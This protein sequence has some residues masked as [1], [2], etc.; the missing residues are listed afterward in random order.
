MGQPTTNAGGGNPV[1]SDLSGFNTADVNFATPGQDVAAI[2]AGG[3]GGGGGGTPLDL[4]SQDPSQ[5]VGDPLTDPFFGSENLGGGG[6]PFDPLTGSQQAGAAVPP[7][8]GGAQSGDVG[9]QQQQRPSGQTA[10]GGP[11]Q[12]VRQPQS[13]LA[14]IARMI[15]GQQQGP[16]WIQ[17]AQQ[18][19]STLPQS[20]FT[21]QPFT[22]LPPS[23]PASFAERFAGAP[24]EAPASPA[25][26]P[27]PQPSPGPMRFAGAEPPTGVAGA[28]STT[29]QPPVTQGAEA[30]A[31][32][33][34][35]EATAAAAETPATPTEAAP[36]TP[37]TPQT[38]QEQAG[39][40][41][42]QQGGQQQRP[43]N[44]LASLA[45]ALQKLLQGNING[46]IA[47]LSGIGPQGG[48]PTAQAGMAGAPSPPTGETSPGAAPTGPGPAPTRTGRGPVGAEPGAAPGQAVP[49]AAPGTATP[50]TPAAATAGAPP[51]APATSAAPGAAPDQAAA[52][53]AGGAPATQ[54][55]ANQRLLDY[56]AGRGPTTPTVENRAPAQGGAQPSAQDNANYLTQRGGHS[57]RG[58]NL[59]RGPYGGY[60][61]NPQMA[62]RLAAAGRE[63]ERTHP[64]QRAQFGEG[65]RDPQ[66]QSV[67]YNRYRTGRGGLAARPGHSLHQSGNAMDIPDG[68]FA[69]WLH[70]GN[71]ARFGLGFPLGDSDPN[72]IQMMDNR[73]RAYPYH[74]AMERRGNLAGMT[75]VAQAGGTPPVGNALPGSRG[76]ARTT[77]RTRITQ[78][79]PGAGGQ[80]S[81]FKTA[82]PNLEGETDHPHT[83]DEVLTGGA[84]YVSLAGSPQYQGQTI[85]LT[86]TDRQTG[87]THHILGYVHDTGKQR[88]FGRGTDHIDVAASR[89]QRGQTPT[90]DR[91]QIQIGRPG[92]P[93]SARETPQRMAGDVVPLPIQPGPNAGP[94]PDRELYEGASR[95][96]E[97]PRIGP[98]QDTPRWEQMM[99]RRPIGPRG[100]E[101]D[102][103]DWIM[104]QA[105]G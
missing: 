39:Y 105:V 24:A 44:P 73:G 52:T 69:N 76:V 2:D 102:L 89:G 30:P 26:A 43:R 100:A 62:N 14:R 3:G 92:G 86:V 47:D 68:A 48:P 101:N 65:D 56:L 49:G 97:F 35:A 32:P 18:Q 103:L 81:G 58:Y 29:S 57:T 33:A 12:Q 38:P 72:H 54:D 95:P 74:P 28:E 25:E 45:S 64:G 50:E 1:S 79:A 60:R 31:A 93:Q 20:P 99:Q 8:V 36:Q 71:A 96:R 34:A 61:A 16:S 5:V 104:R 66:T 7:D 84:N 91:Y 4:T 46:A 13:D 67:Y 78:F 17:G 40:A 59:Q 87:Q 11:P 90:F 70:A 15:S 94:P 82:R 83:I 41:P 75:Q 55:A 6:G 88:Y 37:Q 42:P 22:P 19:P 98:G 53:E 10:T 27:A 9:G 51:A 21:T 63:F 85:P 80:E 23:R 77:P